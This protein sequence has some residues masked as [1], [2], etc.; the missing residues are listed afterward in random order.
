[1]ELRLSI[2]DNVLYYSNCFVIFIF[3]IK[4]I[5][6]FFNINSMYLF[7]ELFRYIIYFV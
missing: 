6:K 1:M 2:V 4:Y 7:L 3:W 5:D